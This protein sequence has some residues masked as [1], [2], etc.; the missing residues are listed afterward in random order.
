MLIYPF[1]FTLI[2]YF[3]NV[4]MPFLSTL[5]WWSSKYKLPSTSLH[6]KSEITIF[7]DYL[8][9]ICVK[10]YKSIN[11]VFKHIISPL[12]G[13]DFG[14]AMFL[15]VIAKWSISDDNIFSHPSSKYIICLLKQYS[16]HNFLWLWLDLNIFSF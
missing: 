9:F 3:T 13:L 15:V 2:Y 14:I 16:L 1:F 7:Y 6:N 8:G 4:T 11:L 10:V 12:L 5:F